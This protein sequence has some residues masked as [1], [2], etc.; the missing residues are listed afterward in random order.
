METLSAGS[1]TM[2]RVNSVHLI[3]G[4][5]EFLAERATSAVIAEVRGAVDNPED[6]P[7]TR[8]RAGDATAPEL[9][10]L[11]SPSLFAEDRIIV[12]DA[13]GEAG[14]E[15]AKL[16]TEVAE[17]PPEGVTLVVCHSGGGRAKSMVA[18]L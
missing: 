12:L 16:V 5:E 4:D 17:N 11:L 10:E 15:P 7:I 2:R 6:I 8:L 9:A 1:G 13:A 18:A 3:L 14:K